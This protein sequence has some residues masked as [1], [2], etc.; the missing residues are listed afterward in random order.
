[1]LTFDFLANFFFSCV[2]VVFLSK[3]WKLR[4]ESLAS[5]T[6]WRGRAGEGVCHQERARW[7]EEP[8]PGRHVWNGDYS[9][10]PWI[11]SLTNPPLYIMWNWSIPIKANFFYYFLHK[12]IV[13]HLLHSDVQAILNCND[14]IFTADILTSH[15]RKST[16]VNYEMRKMMKKLCLCPVS[17]SVYVVTLPWLNETLK[18]KR[19]IINVFSNTCAFPNM[20]MSVVE[21]AS[22]YLCVTFCTSQHYPDWKHMCWCAGN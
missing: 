2:S 3:Q 21:K 22:W 19:D 17:E 11:K 16:A 7:K 5:V 18:M 12:Y 6:L 8:Q 15:C 9:T 10:G 13:W 20:M 1:M 14:Y 4:K